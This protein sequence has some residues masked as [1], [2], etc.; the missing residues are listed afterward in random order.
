MILDCA[1]GCRSWI[2]TLVVLRY[3]SDLS[4]LALWLEV[5]R[6][7]WLGVDVGLGR[8]PSGRKTTWQPRFLQ[9]E[10]RNSW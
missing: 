2:D 7:L 10:H 3:L 9:L 8:R 1:L 4:L 5:G 6:Y